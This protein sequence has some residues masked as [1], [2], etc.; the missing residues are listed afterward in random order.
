MKK[1]KFLTILFILTLVY[2]PV[3]YGQTQ[4]TLTMPDTVAAMGDTITVPIKVSTTS[5]I[6]LAQ[7]VIEF[8]SSVVEFYDAVAGT[9]APGFL[10]SKNTSLP[11][12]VTSTETDKNL[13]LQ[14]SGGGSASFTGQLKEVVNV[15]F[16]V[17]AA[18]GKSG[19]VFDQI[20]NHT[21]LTTTSLNDIAS[22]DIT[23]K[24]GEVNCNPTAINRYGNEPLPEDFALHQNYPNPF[25]PKTTIGFNL[26]QNS[27]VKI[28]IFNEM[29]QE[30]TTLLNRD[31]RAGKHLVQWNGL[32]KNGVN[33]SSGVYF[34]QVETNINKAVRKMMLMR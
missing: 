6:G 9:D 24:D 12:A 26:N 16:I 1:Y 5:E 32:D 28:K 13:L 34:Y 8:K 10:L 31:L 7:F 14:L 2:I 20:S 17:K 25:N 21:F 23:F 11:F 33:V 19:L 30:M 4:A 22:S 29:G 15:S 3:A 18:S 27:I